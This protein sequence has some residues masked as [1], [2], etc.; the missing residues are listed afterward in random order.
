MAA[1]SK[2]SVSPTPIPDPIK[3]DVERVLQSGL[4]DFSLRELLGVLVSSVGQA[5]RRLY[6]SK[7][8]Q[9]KANGFY[10][11][12]VAL[13]SIPIDIEVPRTRS[14]NF[15]PTT[16]PPLYQRGYTEETQALLFALL[17]SSRSSMPPATPCARWDCP[18]PNRIWTM[19]R[20][21]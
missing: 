1:G 8:S 6:L 16:L 5:E 13:G 20:L 2:K 3:S 14:G 19:W 21:D 10:P 12:S 15:R 7:Q 4:A 18:A 17:A 9:D 11:R